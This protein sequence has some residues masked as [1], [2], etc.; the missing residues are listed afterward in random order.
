ML[1]EKEHG[2]RCGK[3]HYWVSKEANSNI[4][5]ILLPG[6]SVGHNGFIKQIEYFEGKY[7]IL[8]WDAPGNATSYPFNFNF[9]INDKAVWLDEI[10]TK[11]NLPNPVI[12]GHSMGGYVA[13][14]YTQNFPEKLKGFISLSSFPLQKKYT[15]AFELF[16][17]KWITGPLISLTKWM[18]WESI[19]NSGIENVAYSEESKKIMRENFKLYEDDKNR[20]YDL[21]YQTPKITTEAIEADLPYE[22][23]CP[24]L[25]IYG[26]KDKTYNGLQKNQSWSQDTGYKLEIVEN[27][28]HSS[29]SD[30]PEKVNSLIENFIQTIKL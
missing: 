6:I 8:A 29:P 20:Y 22:F 11:E 14:L 19:V 15:S 27:T 26:D 3:I 12:I 25:L 10:I 1:E 2:T 30:N 13:Q 4:S 7:N 28:G 18:S 16:S 9:N 17:N 21:M 5:L 23:K 24:V